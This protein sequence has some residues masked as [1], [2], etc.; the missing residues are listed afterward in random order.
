MPPQV[1]SVRVPQAKTRQPAAMNPQNQ[2]RKSDSFSVIGCHSI[3][4]DE[5]INASNIVNK[6]ASA[7]RDAF[8]F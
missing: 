4:A 8:A 2:K 1:L 5:A 3:A 7:G 6:N